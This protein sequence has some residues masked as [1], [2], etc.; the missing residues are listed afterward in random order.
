LGHELEHVLLSRDG[1]P[2]DGREGYATHLRVFDADTNLV[3]EA[4]QGADGTP[5]VVATLGYAEVRRDYDEWGQVSEEHY[6]DAAGA[7]TNSIA[8]YARVRFR[9]D[10]RGNKIEERYFDAADHPLVGPGAAGV[11]RRFDERGQLLAETR[12]DS[13]GR[14]TAGPDG[15]STIRR[16]YDT[17]GNT[18]TTEYVDTSGR[19]LAKPAPQK[20]THVKAR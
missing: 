16:T 9:Y 11:L 1:G 6:L 12:L 17:R 3:S 20:D 4:Y 7:P 14:P 5:R 15:V 19:P 10:D 13:T 18:M 2:I 8:G